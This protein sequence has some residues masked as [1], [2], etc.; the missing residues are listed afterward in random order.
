MR[1]S[2]TM[3]IEFWVNYPIWPYYLIHRLRYP[4]Q[5]SVAL[6]WSRI[7][8]AIAIQISNFPNVKQAFF[9]RKTETADATFT[10]SC[11]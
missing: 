10:R 2:K 5:E 1:I 7:A 6:F 11:R 4:K 8:F 9:V 3:V